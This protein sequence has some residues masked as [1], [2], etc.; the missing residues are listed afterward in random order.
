MIVDRARLLRPEDF[1]RTVREHGITAVLSTTLLPDPPGRA[2]GARRPA[3]RRPPGGV[4]RESL[5]PFLVAGGRSLVPGTLVNQYGPTECTMT[6][7]RYAVP[8]A[9]DPSAD[10]VGTPRAGAVIRVLDADLAPVPDGM[11]GE[12]YIGEPAWP[13]A[14]AA[15][16][17][18][19]P[20]AS[21]PTRTARPAPAS[22][23]PATSAGGDP[24]ACTTP[25]GPT[26][27]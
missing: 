1:A 18:A 25:A 3:G 7:T 2:A 9:T 8:A 22:T 21:Y 26:G 17:P 23:A 27:R 6:T 24:R 13:A 4:Q 20:H 12:V 5:R 10:P 11:V 14:T 15:D 19:R 16:R